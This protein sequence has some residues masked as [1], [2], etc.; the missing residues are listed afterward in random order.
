MDHVNSV[1]TVIHSDF[2]N[3]IHTYKV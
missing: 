2:E 3:E 1:L